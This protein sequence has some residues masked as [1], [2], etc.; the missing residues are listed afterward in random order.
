MRGHK[1]LCGD[2][3]DSVA[4]MAFTNRSF[5]VFAQK[6]KGALTVD[7][8]WAVEVFDFGFVS[9]SEEGVVAIGFGVF[10]GDPFVWG[11]AI[12]VAA[13][14]HEGTGANEPTHF[15]V[16]EGVAEVEF[17]HFVFF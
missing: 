2:S 6:V 8:V 4:V 10:V 1:H 16:V 14:D 7:G 12:V 3:N 5:E 13:F 15:G 17:E 11:H 9:K